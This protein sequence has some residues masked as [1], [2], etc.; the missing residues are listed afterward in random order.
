MKHFS[1]SLTLLVAAVF[2]S[3]SPALAQDVV[4]LHS[5]TIGA[6]NNVTVVYSKNFATCAHLRFSNATCTQYGPL[7]HVANIFCTQGNMVSVTMPSTAFVAGFGP[8][9]PV[10]LVHGNNSNVR[11]A[12]VTVAYDGAYGTGCAGAAGTPVLGAT[13]AAPPAGGSLDLTVSNGPPGSLAVLGLGLTQLT[14]P[15]FGCNLLIGAVQ[16]TVVVPFG[17]SGS[18]GFSLP[19]P[20]GSGGV[21]FTAQAFVLDIGG[22]QGFSATNGLLVQVL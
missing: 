8:G 2:L 12:C 19:L 11:S 3:G 18:G 9:I 22:P 15:L 7:T 17:G 14:F 4:T 10:F 20:L 21:S 16:G 5:V 6:T 1:L 13:N